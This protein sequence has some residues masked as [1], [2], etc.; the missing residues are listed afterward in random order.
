MY[1]IVGVAEHVLIVET[2]PYELSLFGGKV[3]AT[4]IQTGGIALV[5]GGIVEVDEFFEDWEAATHTAEQNQTAAPMLAELLRNHMVAYFQ[6]LPGQATPSVYYRDA[7]KPDGISGSTCPPDI[8]Y[9]FCHAN[10]EK[11]TLITELKKAVMDF[12]NDINQD[13]AKTLYGIA[14]FVRAIHPSL[15][16]SG[17]V[18]YVNML[19]GEM[20]T[21]VDAEGEP[22]KL[23]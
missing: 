18:R 12:P 11:T 21:V 7:S 14:Q 16:H 8:A 10:D 9:T 19:T 1:V 5:A 3:V 22:S 2:G 20:L 6:H 23:N 13:H 17:S 4:T 15:D